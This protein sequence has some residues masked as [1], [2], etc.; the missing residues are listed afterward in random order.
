M[1]AG[2]KLVHRSGRRE[3][4]GGV[5]GVSPGEIRRLLWQDDGSQVMTSRVPNP[6]SAGA[7]YVEVALTIDLHAIGHTLFR[8]TLF[9]AEDASVAE[10]AVFE[11]VHTNI[12]P[13]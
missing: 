13:R 7:G 5:I 9:L 10:F 8:S 6:H 4:K 12:P 2:R 11:V 1:C 3:V